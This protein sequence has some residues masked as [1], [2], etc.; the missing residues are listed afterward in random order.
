MAG[1]E[2]WACSAC[3]Y[4]HE[5]PEEAASERCVMCEAPRRKRAHVSS[6]PPC[7]TQATDTS[8]PYD[9]DCSDAE[10]SDDGSDASFG[11]PGGV[12][13]EASG[14]DKVDEDLEQALA[15]YGEG[16]AAVR[17]GA[18]LMIDL[19]LEP[20]NLVPSEVCKAWGMCN[21]LQLRLCFEGG[22]AAYAARSLH[23]VKVLHPGVR[24]SILDDI[25]QVPYH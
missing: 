7:S 16:T 12:S 25:D 6:P 2:P 19:F 10:C 24:E 18:V 15:T 17:R 23:S 20:S 5:E 22:P 8:E 9:N 13:R 21:T 11:F 14:V 4:M 3:T 1:Y